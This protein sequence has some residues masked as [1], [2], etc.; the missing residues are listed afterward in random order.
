MRGLDF[1]KDEREMHLSHYKILRSHIKNKGA[2]NDRNRIDTVKPE[3]LLGFVNGDGKFISFDDYHEIKRGSVET[4]DYGTIYANV[5]ADLLLITGDFDM[6]K[7]M[8]VAC[9]RCPETFSEAEVKELALRA[10]DDLLD[11]GM[12]HIESVNDE[13]MIITYRTEL[14]PEKEENKMEQ[15]GSQLGDAQ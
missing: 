6:S 15:E 7:V 2:F 3:T 11:L 9:D 14:S 12:I 1:I 5:C 4:M 8:K 13:E 10:L